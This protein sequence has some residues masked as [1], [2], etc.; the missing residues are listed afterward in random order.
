MTV[1]PHPAPSSVAQYMV[2][3]CVQAL[4]DRPGDTLARREARAAAVAEEM[5]AFQPR[6]PVEIMLAGMVVTHAA[7][8]LDTARDAVAEAAGTVKNRTKSLVV[9]LDRVMLGFLRELRL[10]RT[11]PMAGEAAA[12]T[13]DGTRGLAAPS[14]PVHAASPGP[15]QAAPPGPVRAA[16][17]APVQT[18]PSV[19]LAIPLPPSAPS[20]ILAA[21]RVQAVAE[22][23]AWGEAQ[24][25][26]AELAIPPPAARASVSVVAMLA[27]ASPP[28]AMA[29]V[30]RG[31]G[32]ACRPGAAVQNGRRS[33]GG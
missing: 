28:G 15:V 8:V 16:P 33:S 27:A 25:M 18:A 17:S 19:S 31:N 21:P 23:R 5:M 26:A 6:D 24:G 22:A 10:A 32:G 30:T 2:G 9:S 4:R 7:L 13:A 20:A 1:L 12:R 11:R 14:A 3:E 29:P